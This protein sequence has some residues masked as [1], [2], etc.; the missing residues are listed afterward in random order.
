MKTL[1]KDVYSEFTT[2]PHAS[3]TEESMAMSDQLISS[4]PLGQKC[5]IHFH[6]L[7]RST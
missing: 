3:M 2:T 6:R 1:L 7:D 5:L 4:R